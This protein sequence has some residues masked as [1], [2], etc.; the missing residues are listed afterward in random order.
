MDV[1]VCYAM[2]A[3]GAGLV[4]A[5]PATGRPGSTPSAGSP[6]TPAPLRRGG[7][8]VP[9][10]VPGSPAPAVLGA[11]CGESSEV[12][13]T[14][15]LVVVNRVSDG[16]S[17]AALVEKEDLLVENRI[18]I[19]RRACRSRTRH[20]YGRPLPMAR[21]TCPAI[22]R[23]GSLRLRL[24]TLRPIILPRQTTHQR[25]PLNVLRHV[26]RPEPTSARCFLALPRSA[27]GRP[28]QAVFPDGCLTA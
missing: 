17:P 7:L 21:C 16:C 3:L 25:R 19:P 6:A 26:T 23:G 10:A 28:F 4:G 18:S 14:S 8:P 2:A 22:P 24:G 27:A 1:R 9:A 20:L 15:E 12:S 5:Q 11:A 13:E